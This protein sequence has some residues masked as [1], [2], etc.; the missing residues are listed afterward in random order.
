M[1]ILGRFGCLEHM[2]VPIAHYKREIPDEYRAAQS[3]NVSQANR[4]ASRAKR[5]RV[6]SRVWRHDPLGRNEGRSHAREDASDDSHD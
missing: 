1:D 5:A 3:V 2:A 4:V 6:R